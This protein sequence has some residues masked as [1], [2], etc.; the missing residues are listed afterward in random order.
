MEQKAEEEIEANKDK[1]GPDST[2]FRRH[3]TTS[4][5]HADWDDEDSKL[6]TFSIEDQPHSKAA[7][8]SADLS[9]VIGPQKPTLAHDARAAREQ[10]RPPQP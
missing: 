2:Y 4:R 7:A 8:E 10:V 1:R 6:K 3:D 9:D 5:V